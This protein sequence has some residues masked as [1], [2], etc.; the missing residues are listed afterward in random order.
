MVEAAEF[1]KTLATDYLAKVD[2]QYTTYSTITT[3]AETAYN[4]RSSE[5][6]PLE[7][8]YNTKKSAYELA[9]ADVALKLATMNSTN[10]AKSA[11]EAEE[12]K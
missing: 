4:N 5:L 2:S 12:T 3:N 10:A 1:E 11:A 7:S 6:T 8:D 9:A